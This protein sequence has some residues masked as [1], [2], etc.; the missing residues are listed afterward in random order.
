MREAVNDAMDVH[1][2]KGICDG[3]NNYLSNGYQGLPV[4]ITVEGANILTRSLIIFGQGALRCHPYLLAEMKA[5][6][7]VDDL[8]GLAA[9]DEALFGHMRFVAS[10]LLRAFW[11]NLSGGAVG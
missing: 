3:P 4:T 10:N 11:L 6:Q 1:G 2:G 5:A 8:R 7:D 9:F